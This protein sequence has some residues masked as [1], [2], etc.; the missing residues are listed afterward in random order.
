MGKTSL[1]QQLALDLN[2]PIFKVSGGDFGGG[3]A[4]ESERKVNIM[5]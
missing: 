3:F 2:V 1:V 5:F 4:G